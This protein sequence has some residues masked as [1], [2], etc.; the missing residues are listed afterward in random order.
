MSAAKAPTRGGVC[1]DVAALQAALRGFARERDWEQYHSPKNLV[2]ALGGE[3]GELTELFQWLSEEQSWNIMSDP[4]QAEAVRDE[5]ADVLL[6]I[7]R[8]ADLLGVDL[9]AAARAKMRKNEARYPADQV[10]GSARKYTELDR[11]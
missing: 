7:L 10:R 5:L 11:P 1:L 4:G 6:Y 3:A 8:L 9:D 2:M